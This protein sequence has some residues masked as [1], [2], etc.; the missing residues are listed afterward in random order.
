MLSINECF[1]NRAAACLLMPEFLVKRVLKRHNN[2]KKVVLYYEESGSVLSQDQKLLIMRMADTMGAS[3]TA[4]S[5]R[6]RELDLF[7]QKPLE[8][9]LH[10]ELCYG[11]ESY[12]G[13]H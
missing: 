9:Y 4:F 10:T 6:L 12:A 5:N 13:G 11:G 1:T 8:E 7:E 2:S 3:Y